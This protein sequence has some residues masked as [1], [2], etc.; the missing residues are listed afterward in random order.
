MT[1]SLYVKLFKVST[2][3]ASSWEYKG[4]N[5]TRVAVTHPQDDYCRFLRGNVKR[6]HLQTQLFEHKEIERRLRK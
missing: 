6:N 3:S 1:E 4:S 2:E 5:V